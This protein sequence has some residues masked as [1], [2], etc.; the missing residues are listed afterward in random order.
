M[1]VNS[2]R[3]AAAAS[4][5]KKT[6]AVASGGF[7]PYS[8]R[9]E[10]QATEIATSSPIA[11]VEALVALQAA[12][13]VD[14]K[15]RRATRRASTLLDILDTIRL[16]LIDGGIPHATLERLLQA[17]G[18]KREQTGDPKLEAILEQVEIRAQVELA[19]LESATSEN[20]TNA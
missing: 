7:S 12:D 11:S 18:K 14:E 20:I 16:G 8:A 17:L 4:R 6:R 10:A 2:T 3:P 15:A 19:K 5:A 1:K 13:Q 9:T